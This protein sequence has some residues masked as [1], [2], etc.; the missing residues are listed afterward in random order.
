MTWVW[1]KGDFFF[2]E[3]TDELMYDVSDLV[4]LNKQPKDSDV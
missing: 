2:F 4:V 3:N 1:D